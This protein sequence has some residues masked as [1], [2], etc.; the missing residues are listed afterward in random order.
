MQNVRFSLKN[1]TTV[2]T[3][4]SGGIGSAITAAF[5]EEAAYVIS[6]LHSAHT[7]WMPDKNA[8]HTRM[9]CDLADRRNVENLVQALTANYDIDVLINCACPNNVQAD[10]MYKLGPLEAI[11]AIGFDAPYELCSAVARNMAK[12]GTGSIINITS[13]NCEAAW[14][15]NPAYVTVKS[16]LKMLTKCVA[17][18]FGQYGVRANNV[19]PGYVHTQMTDRSFS[20]SEAYRQRSEKTMLNRWGLPNEIADVCLFLASDAASYITGAD[21]VVD[22]GWLAKGL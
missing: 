18:D 10:D 8:N 11:R 13:I 1:K 3:G 21:I 9:I 20:D 7:E 12:R 19:C 22:G 17:L 2:I 16:A 4:A 6:V 14:P 5:L 15:N